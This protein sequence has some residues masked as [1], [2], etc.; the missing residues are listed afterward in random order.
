MKKTLLFTLATIT[1]F[2][3]SH[4]RTWTSSDGSKTFEGTYVSSTDSSATVLIKGR[5]RTFKLSLLSEADRKWIKTEEK[6]LAEEAAK[7]PTG[8]LEDQKVGKRL[9]GKTV[10]LE[11]DKYV[12]QDTKKVPEYYMV[13]YAAS[14]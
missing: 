14:W 2:G 4:A 5:K 8:K 6:R 7:A 1:A 12:S 13:Y 11:G 3:I 10:K 9:M